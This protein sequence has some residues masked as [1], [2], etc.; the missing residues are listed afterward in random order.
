MRPITIAGQQIPALSYDFSPLGMAC[1]LFALYLGISWFFSLPLVVDH[2]LKFWEAIALSHRV[3]KHHF[4]KLLVFAT[5]CFLFTILGMAIIYVGFLLTATI[6]LAA[7][8]SA[9]DSL[10]NQAGSGVRPPSNPSGE[11][12]PPGS[13]QE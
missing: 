6:S 11:A 1:L 9:Y 3:A 7:I 5:L 12:T 10:F 13:P 8:V 2:G 4:F